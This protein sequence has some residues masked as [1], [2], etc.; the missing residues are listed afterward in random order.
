MSIVNGI[1]SSKSQFL[2][3]IVMRGANALETAEVPREIDG[4]E[5]AENAGPASVKISTT[6]P[7]LSC[8]GKRLLWSPGR[9][10]VMRD[11]ENE[12]EQPTWRMRWS[13]TV[14]EPMTDD[15]RRI[16]SAGRDRVHA[17]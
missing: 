9:N 1:V 14:S 17:E 4:A 7:A 11:A 3:S 16:H 10:W 12:I 8:R 15:L 13:P 2:F 6:L 5:N